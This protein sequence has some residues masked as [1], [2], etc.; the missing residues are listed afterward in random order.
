MRLMFLC[1]TDKKLTGNPKDH[2]AIAA[3]AIGK[4]PPGVDLETYDAFA[5]FRW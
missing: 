1:G 3:T 5:E 2:Y 4:A